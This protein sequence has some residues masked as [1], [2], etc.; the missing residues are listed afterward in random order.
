[1]L[2]PTKPMNKNFPFLSWR[3]DSEL[4]LISRSL[5]ELA[6]LIPTFITAGMVLIPDVGCGFGRLKTSEVR[7]LIESYLSAFDRVIHVVYKR[8][9]R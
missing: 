6:A 7:P 3:N 8:E 1:M 5:Q 9:T 2:F 4:S